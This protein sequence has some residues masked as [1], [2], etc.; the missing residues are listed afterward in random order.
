VGQHEFDKR[1]ASSTPEIEKM[2]YVTWTDEET[3][4]RW[5]ISSERVGSIDRP[6]E[7]LLFRMLLGSNDWQPVAIM[8]PP[9]RYNLHVLLDHRGHVFDLPTAVVRKLLDH[10]LP[11]ETSRSAVDFE[12]TPEAREIHAALNRANILNYHAP[13]KTRIE[14]VLTQLRSGWERAHEMEAREGKTKQKFA[15][16]EAE[17]CQT[18]SVLARRGEELANAL[19]RIRELEEELTEAQSHGST[20][21]KQRWMAAEEREMECDEKLS[22][23]NVPERDHPGS[24]SYSLPERVQVLIVREHNLKCEQHDLQESIKAAHA[25]LD[26]K[27]PQEVA[28]R[29]LIQKR[30]NDAADQILLLRERLELCEAEQELLLKNQ[31]H[32]QAQLG[33]LFRKGSLDQVPADTFIRCVHRVC[34]AFREQQRFI[35]QQGQAGRRYDHAIQ[36]VVAQLRW[37]EPW[38]S[39]HQESV[40]GDAAA[41]LSRAVEALAKVASESAEAASKVKRKKAPD[42]ETSAIRW[43]TFNRDA[44]S[45]LAVWNNQAVAQV[46]APAERRGCAKC[47]YKHDAEWRVTLIEPDGTTAISTRECYNFDEVHGAVSTYVQEKWESAAQQTDP[48]ASFAYDFPPSWY[49]VIPSPVPDAQFEVA[50]YPG[51]VR[52]AAWLLDSGDEPDV[53]GWDHNHGQDRWVNASSAREALTLRAQRGRRPSPP[54]A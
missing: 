45:Y 41:A 17:L 23:A 44:R 43:I 18:R 30:C 50:L 20:D 26:R 52:V 39:E 15:K 40:P 27:E 8:N 13:L 47:G 2:L 16:L 42:R 29:G 34:A 35:R 36:Q 11:E 32:A 49:R 31:Q 24:R 46:Q 51:E 48:M 6:P 54:T 7:A 25:A 19:A 14:L 37:L 53:A 1:A 33:S 9:P 3:H 21:W 38:L 10:V 22:L 12:A 5:G 28:Y 4:T